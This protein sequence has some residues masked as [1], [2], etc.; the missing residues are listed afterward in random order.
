MADFFKAAKEKNADSFALILTQ[1]NPE[2]ISD[3]LKNRGL[4]ENDFYIAKVSP[5][6]IPKYLSAAD[7]AISFIKPCFSKLSSSPTKIAE[8]LISGVPVISNRGVGDVAELIEANK[9]GAVL[10][11]FDEKSYLT[12]LAELEELQ[13][14]GD[15]REKCRETARNEFDLEKTAGAK[16]RSIYEKLLR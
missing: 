7:A 13:K 8:Y 11:N 6:E 4:S 5:S 3:L 1:S 16:Y 9:V 10:A 2:M 14:S 15:L 12:A